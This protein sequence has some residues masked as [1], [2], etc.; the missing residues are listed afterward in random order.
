M[1]GGDGD[2]ILG[3]WQSEA[4]WRVSGSHSASDVGRGGALRQG[5]AH[6]NLADYQRW[7]AAGWRGWRHREC[8]GSAT[9]GEGDD[10]LTFFAKAHVRQ[11]RDR[12]V[13]RVWLA[14]VDEREVYVKHISGRKNRPPTEVGLIERLRWRFGGSRALRVCRVHC[15]MARAGVSVPKVLLAARRRGDGAPEDLLVTAAVAAP[16]LKHRLRDLAPEQRQPIL[17]QVGRAMAAMH[18]AGFVHGD[19]TTAN[20]LVPEG[21]EPCWLDNDRTRWLP[22]V[23]RSMCLHNVGAIAC[24]ALAHAPWREVKELLEAYCEARGISRARWRADRLRVVRQ[25]RRWEQRGK[26]ERDRRA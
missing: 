15:A 10:P 14:R 21:G 18:Q 24:R 19:P 9:A 22:M 2:P 7:S 17:C 12:P 16:A 1:R 6:L 13:V 20:V 26:R 3:D 11:M 25:I 23:P 8:P 4:R 5:M